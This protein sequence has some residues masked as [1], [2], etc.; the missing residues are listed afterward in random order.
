MSEATEAIRDDKFVEVTTY[1]TAT[2]AISTLFVAR[3]IDS[4]AV[5]SGG[6]SSATNNALGYSS[7]SANYL[8][9]SETTSSKDVMG[10]RGLRS[11]ADSARARTCSMSSTANGTPFAAR[12]RS[13]R[14]SGSDAS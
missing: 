12:E 5:V 7:I 8:V 13:S 3:M 1:I 6:D 4:D 10:L 9:F 14:M 2:A 11:A